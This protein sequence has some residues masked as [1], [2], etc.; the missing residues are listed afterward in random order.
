[1]KISMLMPVYN[2][3]P[4]LLEKA[5]KSVIAQKHQD[6]EIVIKDGNPDNPAFMNKGI[7]ALFESLGTKL[8]HEA[9][10]DVVGPRQKI[11]FYPA[12]NWCTQH[13]TGDV[14]SFLA[15][16][17]ERGDENV[18][19]Y[20]NEQ[21]EKHPGPFLLYSAIKWVNY[22]SS[23]HS[24]RRPAVLPVTF[25]AL[26]KENLLFTPAV[27]WNR[28]VYEKIGLFD[29]SLNFSADYDYWLRAWQAADTM[30]STRILGT[31]R[32]WSTSSCAMLDRE[33]TEQGNEVKK[34]YQ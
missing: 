8:V 18:L 27:F 34:K 5:I 3:P 9:S 29:L 26:K 20:V 2:T 7:R 25:E 13:A 33:V 10:P 21:F 12:L 28:A 15:G 14:F 6:F 16:D 32:K 17:D 19:T 22:D 31:Y 1:M 30:Y 24:F 23:L 11:S 4:E